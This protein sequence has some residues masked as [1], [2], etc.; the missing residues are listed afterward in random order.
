M[1]ADSAITDEMRAEAGKERSRK[2]SFPVDK[3]A[4]RQWAI[5]VRWPEPPERLYW[6]EAY[7]KGTRF[8][9]I[10]APP[11]FNPFSYHV[12][13]ERMQEPSRQGTFSE[14]PGTRVLNGG[15]EAEYHDA[16]RPGDVIT[17]VSKIVD[18][19][20][21]PGRLGMMLFTITETTWTNQKGQLVRVYRG[22]NIRY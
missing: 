3:S 20:Q 19:Y 13:E 15:G 17:S 12:D 6:D 8:G 22:T 14:A 9:G 2:V 10:I 16:I 7:A 1:M 11:F 5:A 4:I 18:L 21:R